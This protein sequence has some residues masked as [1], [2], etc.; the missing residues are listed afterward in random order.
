MKNLKLSYALLG[1]FLLIVVTAITCSGAENT[2]TPP[3]Q[4]VIEEVKAEEPVL[5]QEEINSEEPVE[6]PAEP[7]KEEVP[8]EA[9]AIEQP[10]ELEDNTDDEEL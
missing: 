8:V 7:V 9:P 6:A 1:V 3:A 10:I 5:I 4:P 2:T